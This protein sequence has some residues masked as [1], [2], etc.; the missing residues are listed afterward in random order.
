MYKINA[1]N[2]NVLCSVSM[3]NVNTEKADGLDVLG[4]RISC[5]AEVV[6]I[7]QQRKELPA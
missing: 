5:D 3:C 2:I 6:D 7:S 4:I 1:Y